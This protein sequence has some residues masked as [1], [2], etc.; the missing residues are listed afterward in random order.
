MCSLEAGGD[1]YSTRFVAR[2]LGDLP[3]GVFIPHVAV[4][5]RGLREREREAGKVAG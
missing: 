5:R 3:G 1:T 2:E 4:S